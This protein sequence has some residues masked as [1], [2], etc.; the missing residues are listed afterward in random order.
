MKVPLFALSSLLATAAVDIPHGAEK[1]LV[2]IFLDKG[3]MGAIVVMQMLVILKLYR[4]LSE[5]R[6]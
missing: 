4:D 1:G 2:E 5:S 6:E 3:V